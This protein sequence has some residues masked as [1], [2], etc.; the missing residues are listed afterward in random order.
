M[1]RKCW[2]RLGDSARSVT[3]SPITDSSEERPRA[4]QGVPGGPGHRAAFGAV[5]R[6][7]HC[8]VFLL[9]GTHFPPAPRA[10]TAGLQEGWKLQ[11]TSTGAKGRLG[12][13]DGASASTGMLWGRP[14][15]GGTAASLS[16][17]STQRG[18]FPS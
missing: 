13:P 10:G 16:S 2:A 3:R 4:F 15:A 1:S 18:P 17:E 14:A 5:E 12:A 7:A 9:T 11:A 8:R 6:P